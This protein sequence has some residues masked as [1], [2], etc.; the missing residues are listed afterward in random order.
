MSNPNRAL[1]NW[2]LRKV[3]HKAPGT[4]VTMADLNK[5]GIDSVYIEKQPLV[6]ASESVE[7]KISFSDNYDGYESFINN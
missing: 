2:I 4:L 5:F 1:G 6:N 3:L 7:Y